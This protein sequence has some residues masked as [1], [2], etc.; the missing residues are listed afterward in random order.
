MQVETKGNGVCRWL[1]CHLD[2]HQSLV[3]VRSLA[4]IWLFVWQH[5]HYYHHSPN[6]G[7]PCRQK[8]HSEHTPL[9]LSWNSPGMTMSRP[10]FTC[11]KDMLCFKSYRSHTYPCEWNFPCVV[12]GGLA[13]TWAWTA[14]PM[15]CPASPSPKAVLMRHESTP[16]R[17]THQRSSW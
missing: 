14:T 6:E 2:F 9:S 13:V 17:P 11:T 10:A 16:Q 7:D 8:L 15:T 4:F 12:S 5:Q 1:W 3:T